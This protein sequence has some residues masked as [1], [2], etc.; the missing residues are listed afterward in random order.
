MKTIGI[1]G[2]MEEE[3]S[4][5]RE[6]SEIINVKNIAESDFY[7]CKLSGKNVVLNRCGI[8]KVNAAIATQIMI[9]MYGVDCVINIGLAGAIN[10]DLKIGDIVVSS[11]AIH[12]DF[13]ATGFGYKLGEIPRASTSEFV[14]DD[15]LIQAAKQCAILANI[16]REQ[17]HIGRVATGD[18]FVSDKEE[19]E[20]IWRKFNAYCAEMEGAA[21]AQTCYLNK[22]PFVII[23]SISDTADGDA[24]GDFNKNIDQISKNAY[25]ILEE[26]VKEL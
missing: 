1:I 22:L 18:V 10:E 20:F 13:D 4:A 3:I 19:K 7:M 11:D 2:A 16:K 26:M 8:G 25:R 24:E 23:R 12:H 17:I 21:I 6:I 5:L 9:D 15:K 14:A